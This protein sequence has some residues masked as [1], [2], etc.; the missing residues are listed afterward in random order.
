MEHII[1][2]LTDTEFCL[3]EQLAYLDEDV[4]KAASDGNNKV[5]FYKISEANKGETI[6]EILSVFDEKALTVL[7]THSEPVCDAQVSGIEWARMIKF[8]KNGRTAALVLEELMLDETGYHTVIDDSGKSYNY[9]LALCFSDGSEKSSEAVVVFKGTTGPKEWADNVRAALLF[10]TPPQRKAL[11]FVEKTAERF[12]N[13]ITVGH[14]KG[15]NK[16]MYTALMCDKVVKCIGFDGQ[17]F[18]KVFLETPEVAERIEKRAD[19]IE[20]YSLT[21]DFV[22]ILLY[23]IP[24]SHQLFCKGYCVHSIGENH[25]PSSFFEQSSDGSD[26]NIDSQTIMV[27]N[28]SYI[29]PK[30]KVAKEETSVETLHTFV[31]YLL[32]KGENVSKVVDYLAKILPIVIVGEDEDGNKYNSRG[33]L[34][35]VLSDPDSLTVIITNLTSFALENKLNVNYLESLL[36]AFG[37]NDLGIL[38]FLLKMKV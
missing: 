16:A 25:A 34:D 6:A 7:K 37:I 15:S 5:E 4:A 27:G 1:S 32:T 33:K 30:F 11:E 36:K 31:D 13:V 22:H 21:G 3:L 19:L 23:Q 14:S 35:T 29:I 17:G 20:N 12:E 38:S 28:T 9:P 18:S 2:M 10:D 24:A 26:E 8:L